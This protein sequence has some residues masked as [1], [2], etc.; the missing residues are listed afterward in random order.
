MHFDILLHEVGELQLLYYKVMRSSS[1]P[2]I[3]F[4][5]PK[6]KDLEFNFEEEEDDLLKS[7]GTNSFAQSYRHPI[8]GV[9]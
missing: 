1:R 2:L 7:L 4:H 9:C 5:V 3:V 6:L 8:D